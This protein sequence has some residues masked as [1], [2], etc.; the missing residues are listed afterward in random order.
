VTFNE[1]IARLIGHSPSPPPPPADAGPPPPLRGRGSPTAGC[2]GAGAQAGL[3]SRLRG[4]GTMR[5]LVERAATRTKLW[6]FCNTWRE[7]GSQ[8]VY[9]I[10]DTPVL[11]C[12]P[13]PLQL[14][15]GDNSPTPQCSERRKVS[16]APVED[17][18]ARRWFGRNA[19]RRVSR[20]LG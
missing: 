3:L 20:H 15:P 7:I 12:L 11:S 2:L 8:G 17:Q 5:S 16:Y 9:A 1:C 10:S 6:Q 14:S 13:D 19:G 18:F 4:R